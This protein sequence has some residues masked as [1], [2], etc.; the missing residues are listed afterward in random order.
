MKGAG[1]S[2]FRGDLILVQLLPA[3]LLLGVGFAQYK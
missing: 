1:Q 2:A 3:D